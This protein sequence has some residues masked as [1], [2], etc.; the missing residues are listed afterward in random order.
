MTLEEFKNVYEGKTPLEKLALLAEQYD[1]WRQYEVDRVDANWL[2]RDDDVR[3]YR[4][5]CA[6]MADRVRWLLEEIEAALKEAEV[7]S[8]PVSWMQEYIRDLKA[9]GDNHGAGEIGLMLKKL[10]GFT[11]H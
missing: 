10:E 8:I 11:E 2:G 9:G 3:Y 6:A 7:Q 1:F 4:G 5:E